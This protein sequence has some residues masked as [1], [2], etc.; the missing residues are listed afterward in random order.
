M[1]K[2][3]CLFVFILIS[4]SYVNSQENS[5][6]QN[7]EDIQ[8]QILQS[9]NDSNFQSNETTENS[10]ILKILEENNKIIA[11]EQQK[12]IQ[13]QEREKRAAQEKKRAEFKEKHKNRF[14][15]AYLG[16]GVNFSS[17]LVSE[18]SDKIYEVTSPV[19]LSFTT[20]FSIE[21]QAFKLNLDFDSIYYSSTQSKKSSFFSFSLGFSPLHSNYAFLG[22]FATF[23]FESI[24]NY[25]YSSFGV[26]G[27]FIIHLGK[28]LGLYV[29]I[30]AT[31]RNEGKWDTSDHITLT[32]LDYA[33]TWRVSPSVGVVIQLLKK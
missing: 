2:I 10:D 24:N 12:N 31:K 26:S 14:M 17:P 15:S 20:I 13:E 18:I 9:I 4:F 29:N 7:L 5:D 1:K 25:S 32:S 21:N 27:N 23:G 22:L 28:A 19:G 30:D 6:L 11:E 33:D 16:G 3:I 8:N